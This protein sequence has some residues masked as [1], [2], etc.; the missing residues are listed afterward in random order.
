MARL[1]DNLTPEIPLDDPTMVRLVV[2]VPFCIVWLVACALYVACRGTRYP[3]WATLIL[4]A[5]CAIPFAFSLGESDSV[6]LVQILY[7]SATGGLVA[8]AV[9]RNLILTWTCAGALATG[10]AFGM[11]AFFTTLFVTP[12]TGYFYKW[13]NGVDAAILVFV[14]A[15]AVFGLCGAVCSFVAAVIVRF[16]FLR[17]SAWSE[18]GRP[19]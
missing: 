13:G 5:G 2:A 6:R 7:G 11:A 12:E 15:A 3:L 4:L 17:R 14:L 18:Y 16:S 9:R 1:A 8:I 10:L 19:T